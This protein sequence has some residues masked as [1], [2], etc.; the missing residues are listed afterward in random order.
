MYHGGRQTELPDIDRVSSSR[1]QLLTDVDRNTVC[2]RATAEKK[3]RNGDA[4]PESRRRRS[5]YE[6]TSPRVYARSVTDGQSRSVWSVTDGVA[7]SRRRSV[8]RLVGGNSVGWRSSISITERLDS[9]GDTDTN[10]GDGSRATGRQHTSRWRRR[11]SGDGR[12]RR[13]RGRGM[14]NTREAVESASSA[15]H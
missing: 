5:F 2:E 12:R 1:D 13:Q 10:C 7:R 9:L 4:N 14:K 3:P 6:W 8:V 11:R 15:R